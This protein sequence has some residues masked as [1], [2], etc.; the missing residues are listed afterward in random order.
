MQPAAD[1]RFDF[2]QADRLRRALRVSGI[3]VQEMAEEL[4][5]SR[6][7]VTNWINGHNSPR[8]RDLVGFAFKTGYP[9][10]WLENGEGFD[11]NMPP[12]H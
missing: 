4:Q 6:N 12:S 2:D 3:S 9:V 1:P 5:V 8:R 7:S 10:K 11:P